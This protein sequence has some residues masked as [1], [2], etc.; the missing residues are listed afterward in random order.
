MALNIPT[1]PRPA[2]IPKIVSETRNIEA[3]AHVALTMAGRI[4]RE[5]SPLP[6]VRRTRDMM[7][8]HRKGPPNSSAPDGEITVAG[9]RTGSVDCRAPSP[10]V[11]P[12]VCWRGLLSLNSPSVAPVA[13]AGDHDIPPGFDLPTQGLRDQRRAPSPRPSPDHHTA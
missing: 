8:E 12:F 2:K 1:G 11:W 3:P 9:G 4:S 5:F 13:L 6:G 10:P 7:L